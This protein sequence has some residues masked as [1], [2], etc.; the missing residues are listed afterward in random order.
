VTC[1]LVTIGSKKGLGRPFATLTPGEQVEALRWNPIISSVLIWQFSLPKF[2]MIATLKRI[3]SYGTKTTVLFWGLALSSQACVL[4]TS[5]WWFTQCRPVEYGWNRAIEGECS[6]VSIL[7]NL[8]YF[9]SAYSAFLDIFF[10]FYPIPFIMKLN[11][12]MRTRLAMSIAMG[13]SSL[14]FIVAVY[15]LV[16]FEE[17][18]TILATDPTLPVPCLDVLGVAE[19]T[20]LIICASLPTLG[21]IIR[22]MSKPQ[23]TDN[24]SK[25]TS[26]SSQNRSLANAQRHSRRMSK[27]WEMLDEQAASDAKKLGVDSFP[28]VDKGNNVSKTNITATRSIETLHTDRVSGERRPQQQNVDVV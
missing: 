27:T 12:P 5:I 2:A 28:L 13:L 16:I 7:A 17:I 15:K 26:N 24:S 25:N 23:K 11:M 9:T 22:L 20:T 19:G 10:A 14:A 21:P 8:G 6:D 4:A 18:F 3:L 1:I